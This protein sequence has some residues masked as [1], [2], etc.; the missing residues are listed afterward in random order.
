MNG[1]DVPTCVACG[2]DLTVK[3][4]L[5]ECEHFTEVGQRHHDAENSRQLIQGTGVT[6]VF[7]FLQG[8]EQ[9]Y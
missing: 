6:E 8:I 7:D 3:H 5:I 2:C 9:F 1:E 4:I